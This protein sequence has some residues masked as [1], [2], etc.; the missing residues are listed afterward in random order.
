MTGKAFDDRYRTVGTRP[1]RGP[2]PRGPA[3]AD[4]YMVNSFIS[5]LNVLRPGDPG[6]DRACGVFNLA[7]VPK[8]AEAVVACTVEARSRMY[9]LVQSR[10]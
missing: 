2:A 4:R 8:P 1:P 10:A 3:R 9:W 7:N 5:D 6:Y